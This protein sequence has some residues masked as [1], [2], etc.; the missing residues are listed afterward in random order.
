MYLSR[1]ALYYESDKIKKQYNVMHLA[2]KNV[3]F[4]LVYFNKKK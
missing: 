1:A 4:W 3:G 2:N